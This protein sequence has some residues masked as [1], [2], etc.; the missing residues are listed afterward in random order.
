MVTPFH[1]SPPVPQD[2]GPSRP[3]SSLACRCWISGAHFGEDGNRPKR[4][5][6]GRALRCKRSRARTCPTYGRRSRESQC[7]R[8]LAHEAAFDQRGSDIRTRSGSF[9]AVVPRG[10]GCGLRRLPCY[11]I[12][13]FET[14][15]EGGVARIGA[16]LGARAWANGGSSSHL[17][18]HGMAI[19][20]SIRAVLPSWS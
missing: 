8:S 15:L 17:A 1:A 7:R 14:L 18:P 4:R 3:A 2:E 20:R 9:A 12:A 13:T 10:V 19:P 16:A 11:L 6:W 5:V